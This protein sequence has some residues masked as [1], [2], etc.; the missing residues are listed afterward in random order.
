MPRLV[1]G[2]DTL[3]TTSCQRQIFNIASHSARR[4]SRSPVHI[5]RSLPLFQLAT[6]NSLRIS[7][8]S[9]CITPLSSTRSSP[10]LTRTFS[11]SSHHVITAGAS[12]QPRSPPLLQLPLTT[13]IPD[14]AC[15]AQWPPTSSPKPYP[16]PPGKRFHPPSC[17]WYIMCPWRRQCRCRC[18]SQQ[19]G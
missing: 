19:C 11:T 14:P 17:P 6:H 3:L 4:H 1:L 5:I 8:A 10:F 18:L 9:P 12:L 7:S 13:L 2:T 16:Y 15:K